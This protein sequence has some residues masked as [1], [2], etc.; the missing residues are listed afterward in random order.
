MYKRCEQTDTC[1]RDFVRI[2]TGEF[3]TPTS[4]LLSVC[5]TGRASV[6]YQFK[7]WMCKIV[8]HVSHFWFLISQFCTLPLPVNGSDVTLLGFLY[9]LGF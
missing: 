5:D 3:Q 1:D 9:F 4:I 8:R 6:M 7:T 2:I